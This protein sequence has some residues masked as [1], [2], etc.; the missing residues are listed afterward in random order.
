MIIKSN[1]VEFIEAQFDRLCL[2]A[3]QSLL[4]AAFNQHYFYA[5]IFLRSSVF[6]QQCLF[7][8]LL[9]ANLF[10]CFYLTLS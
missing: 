6:R 2:I 7:E 9:I 4:S 10:D 8:N 3:A 5:T 1:P